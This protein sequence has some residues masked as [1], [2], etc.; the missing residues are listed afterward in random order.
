MRAVGRAGFQPEKGSEMTNGVFR[1]H[2][3]LIEKGVEK[4]SEMTKGVILGAYFTSQNYNNAPIVIS[5]P[6][7]RKLDVRAFRLPGLRELMKHGGELSFDNRR[8]WSFR[9][10]PQKK[11]AR[12]RF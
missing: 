12:L 9:K 8:N 10:Y 7:S 6:F 5:D 4:G 2:S 1:E 3:L 11:I